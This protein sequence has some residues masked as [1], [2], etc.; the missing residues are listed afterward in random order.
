[1]SHLDAHLKFRMLFELKRIHRSLGKTTIYVT[2]D[3]VEALAL[4]DRIAVMSDAVL[5]QYGTRD[6]LYHRPVEPVRRRFHRRAPDQ[7]LQRGNH[8]GQRRTGLDGGWL[9]P[10][11]PPRR[12]T[13]RRLAPAARRQVTI[14]IRPQNF[15]TTPSPGM[16][17][18]TARVVLN[19]YLGE[20]SIVTLE[21]GLTSFRALAAPDLR[22][23]AGDPMSLYY[24]SSDVMVFDP[25]SEK[26]IG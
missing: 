3:Q 4:A 13:H 23:V 22:L 9:G 6:D 10:G 5:Q 21:A 17:S 8:R 25:K 2:H 11:L 1:M 24:R 18:V 19:E 26:F 7:F 20:L 14:G 15:L 12:L 16:R